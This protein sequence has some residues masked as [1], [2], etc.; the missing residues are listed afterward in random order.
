[1]NCNYRNPSILKTKK[2]EVFFAALQYGFFLNYLKNGFAPFL[3]AAAFFGALGTLS[4]T[5]NGFWLL[6][7]MILILLSRQLDLHRK[8]V[9][10]LLLFLITGAILFPFFL[11]NKISYGAW[12]LDGSRSE[13]IFL[14]GMLVKI[15]ENKT[16]FSRQMNEILKDVWTKSCRDAGKNTPDAGTY[17]LR[18]DLEMGR[19]I[20]ASPAT[21][22]KTLFNK[23]AVS[24]LSQSLF[25]P[26]MS[27][28]Q[29]Q[30][31]KA[32]FNK[33]YRILVQKFSHLITVI[34]Y[35]VWL[36][37]IL[38]LAWFSIGDPLKGMGMY[39]FL[40][41][42]F[43][44]GYYLLESGAVQGF[45]CQL[46]VLPLLYLTAGWGLVFFFRIVKAGKEEQ[47]RLNNLR[48]K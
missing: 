23:H 47:K 20:A 15:K 10:I 17:Y 1:M 26:Q 39:S 32:R 3:A 13:R 46:P 24:P 29:E 34:A 12:R 27:Y 14:A 33:T 2:T 38:G 40:V 43:L 42:I 41:L 8:L 45:R 31:G 16:D 6:P 30:L 35:A 28:L 25:R 21:Y 11:R 18:R 4:L 36:L 37:V 48:L 5:G 22:V 9:H 44:G 7:G 19:I